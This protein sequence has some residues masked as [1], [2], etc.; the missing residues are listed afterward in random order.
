MYPEEIK[1]KMWPLPISDLSYV[2]H[3]TGLPSPTDLT[4]E[5]YK[6]ACCL[7]R[8]LWSGSPVRHLGVHTGRVSGADCGRQLNLFDEIDYEKLSRMDATVDGIRKRFGADAMMRASFL[9]QPIDHMSGGISREKR[10][11]DYDHVMIR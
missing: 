7:F 4:I 11:V 10:A 3:Q 1:E 6:A 8:E 5:I 2:S 9:D